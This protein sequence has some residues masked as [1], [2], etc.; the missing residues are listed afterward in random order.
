M[1]FDPVLNLAQK[2]LQTETVVVACKI[3]I[4]WAMGHFRSKRRDTV[5]TLLHIRGSVSNL[6]ECNSKNLFGMLA[7]RKTV[8][9]VIGELFA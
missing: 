9:K 6:T 3:R 4:T 8:K 1:L 2:S 7:M 5:G